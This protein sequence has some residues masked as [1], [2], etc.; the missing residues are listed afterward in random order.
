MSVCNTLLTEDRVVLYTDTLA[1][2]GTT[3]AQL[4]SKVETANGMAVSTRGMFCVGNVFKNDLAKY[5]N[6][7]AAAVA[8]RR[9]LGIC[10]EEA[11]DAGAEVN[12]AGWDGGPVLYRIVRMKGEVEARLVRMSRGWTMA[13][14]LGAREYPS[15]ITRAQAEKLALVQQSL[16]IKHS[17]NMCIGGDLQETTVDGSGARTITVM[18]YPDKAKTVRLIERAERGLGGVA[19]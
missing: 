3:P 8:F 10:P 2:R 13:P 5:T 9:L 19:A 12:L 6:V 11:L 17:L 15:V 18:E 7:H 1:Y 4:H 16:C 14:T